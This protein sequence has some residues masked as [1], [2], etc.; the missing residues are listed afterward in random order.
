MILLVSETERI[1]PLISQDYCED[2]V[3]GAERELIAEA[4][5]GSLL[6]SILYPPEHQQ[7]CVLT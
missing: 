3:P 1:S 5:L 4:T 6:L 2:L 7:R